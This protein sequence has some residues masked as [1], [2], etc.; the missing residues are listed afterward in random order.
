MEGLLG[1]IVLFG[2][3]L[4]FSRLLNAAREATK[5]L[6][7]STIDVSTG[8]YCVQVYAGDTIKCRL[9][10]RNVEIRLYGM[11][12]PKEAHDGKPAQYFA[13]EATGYLAGRILNA[14][15]TVIPIEED[16][17][18]RTVARVYVGDEDI[19][20]TMIKSGMAE[21]YRSNLAE[22]YITQY[23]TAEEEARNNELGLWNEPCTLLDDKYRES[24]SDEIR[25]ESM[26]TIETI[27]V[28]ESAAARFYL[29]EPITEIA[30]A[31]RYLDAAVSAHFQGRSDL[32]EELI[33]LADI[34]AIREWTDS[35]W[36]KNSPHVQYRS[37]SDA[38]PTFSREQRGK[39]R[40]PTLAEKNQ[41]LM[42]DGYH[43]RF[44]GIPL[45]RKEVREQFRRLFPQVQI[46]GDK[47]TE[48]H[49]ALQAMWL[50]YDHVLPH[51]RGGKS[52]VENMLITCAPC[53]YARMSYT[54]DEVGLVDPRTRE[55]IRSTWDGLERIMNMKAPN[56]EVLIAKNRQCCDDDLKNVVPAQ[57]KEA[58]Q[59]IQPETIS[60]NR[61]EN[62]R[63]WGL[64]EYVD[65]INKQ[66]A[67]FVSGYL[68]DLIAFFNATPELFYI[69][70]GIGKNPSLV[71]KNNLGKTICY[72][73]NDNF[74]VA[75][76]LPSQ[77]VFMNNLREKYNDSLKWTLPFE[78]GK[79]P[80]LNKLANLT[81]AEFGMLKEFILEMARAANDVKE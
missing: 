34:P 60:M 17:Y 74:Q 31:A 28:K 62:Q 11:V 56:S 50:Q 8:G 38:P 45:I 29:R 13:G 12:A 46:W 5:K 37:V 7:P 48:C 67:P 15:V 72:L 44:C 24:T 4:F 79:W 53:N 16:E 18:M 63:K 33:R 80:S 81:S 76:M 70:P 52:G 55:P 6:P 2:T 40:M 69:K 47:I 54:L 21:T 19:S 14:W 61:N 73:S 23:S 32:A 77:I 3:Y 22:P 49:A 9:G 64:T 10:S 58:K 57:A 43:C 26:E 66:N 75:F 59:I 30:D 78:I 20:L 27:H 25:S 71:I 35:L 42:R 41:L 51:S 39:E 36:G 68:I 65:F 1:A